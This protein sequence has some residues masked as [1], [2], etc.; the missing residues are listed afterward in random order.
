MKTVIPSSWFWRAS[1]THSKFPS[2]SFALSTHRICAW[3]WAISGIG[4]VRFSVAR[5]SSSTHRWH[6]FSF[7]TQS[8]QKICVRPWET[9]LLSKAGAHTAVHK[10]RF[11]S[12]VATCTTSP[13]KI[14]MTLGA[15]FTTNSSKCRWSVD[16]GRMSS[17]WEKLRWSIATN[18]S[19]EILTPKLFRMG[20]TSYAKIS[21]T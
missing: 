2:Q 3:P 5:N 17:F 12:P 6:L 15:S 7:P 20:A 8:E 19:T 14:R 16:D 18:T 10:F 13:V 4:T 1:S 9:W 11:S 21:L